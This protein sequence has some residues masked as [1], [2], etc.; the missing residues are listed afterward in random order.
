MML[1]VGHV[2]HNVTTS[3]KGGRLDAMYYHHLYLQRAR[4]PF[5]LVDVS[6]PFRFAS[7][8]G[9]ALDNIQFCSGLFIDRHGQGVLSYGVRDCIARLLHFNLSEVLI[10]DDRRH[11][12]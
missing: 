5:E 8:F 1:V 10:H 3:M 4:P 9:S 6:R 11:G 7:E 12:A 2:T